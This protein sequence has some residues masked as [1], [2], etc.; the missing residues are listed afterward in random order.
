MLFFD[1]MVF[2]GLISVPKLDLDGAIFFQ[3]LGTTLLSFM[4]AI[5]VLWI[6]S[7]GMEENVLEYAMISVKAK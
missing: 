7:R 1:L 4:S 2:T 6:E 3:Q 5:Y